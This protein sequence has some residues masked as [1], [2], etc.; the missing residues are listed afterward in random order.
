[1]ILLHSVV[2]NS[3]RGSLSLGLLVTLRVHGLL[4]LLSDVGLL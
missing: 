3:L 1:M 2:N 4:T